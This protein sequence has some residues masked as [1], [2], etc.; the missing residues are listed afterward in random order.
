M[1]ISWKHEVLEAYGIFNGLPYNYDYWTYLDAGT[2]IYITIRGQKGKYCLRI[3]GRESHS[4]RDNYLVSSYHKSFEL[5]EGAVIRKLRVIQD[6][7]SKLIDNIKQS[8]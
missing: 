2:G 7:F 6:R 3:F 1:N 4:L 8:K 5:A